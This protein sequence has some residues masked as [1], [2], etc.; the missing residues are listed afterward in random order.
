MRMGY[1]QPS[2]T[3]LPPRISFVVLKNSLV[4]ADESTRGGRKREEGSETVRHTAQAED[5]VHTHGKPCLK[6][7]KA[8]KTIIQHHE[9]IDSMQTN[10]F[11]RPRSFEGS[12]LAANK[13]SSLL[14]V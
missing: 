14:F 6:L 7:T 11:S 8:K 3:R 9:S 1:P 12:S 13:K 4:L 10:D 2:L 5:T